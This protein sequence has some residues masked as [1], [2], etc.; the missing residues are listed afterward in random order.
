MGYYTMHRIKIINEYNTKENL[1][2]L[3]E[4]IEKVSE[5][6]GFFNILDSVITDYIPG[7]IFDFGTK[8]YDCEKDMRIVSRFAPEF[9]IQVKGKGENDEIWAYTFQNGEQYEE[10]CSY[11][12]DD[13]NNEDE[14]NEENDEEKGN[15]EISE[16]ILNDNNQS[17]E[18][19]EDKKIIDDEVNRK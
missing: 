5:Y 9:L 4:L 19:N 13:E 1:E 3:V 10:D 2:K 11:F 16:N 17:N 14:K 15:N 7:N 12:T 18:I 6:K 8:W